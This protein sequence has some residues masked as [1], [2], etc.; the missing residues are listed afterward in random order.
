LCAETRGKTLHL[1]KKQAKPVP[2]MR[3][4]VKRDIYASPRDF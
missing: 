4:R 2:Q 3:K 1:L